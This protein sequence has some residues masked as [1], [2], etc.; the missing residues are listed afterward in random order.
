MVFVTDISGLENPSMIQDYQ[1]TLLDA[2]MVYTTTHYPHYPL[3][4]GELLLRLSEVQRLTSISRQQIRHLQ[5]TG[6]VPR[7]N[8][9]VELLRHQGYA[10]SGAQLTDAQ[11]L[12]VI[13][14]NYEHEDITPQHSFDPIGQISE[15]HISQQ[16]D[17]EIVEVSRKTSAEGSRH[18]TNKRKTTSVTRIETTNGYSSQDRTPAAA[19]IGT[20]PSTSVRSSDFDRSYSYGSNGSEQLPEDLTSPRSRDKPSTDVSPRP[21]TSPPLSDRFKNAP[22]SRQQSH[23]HQHVQRPQAI[24]EPEIRRPSTSSES[25]FRDNYPPSLHNNHRLSQAAD[26]YSNMRSPVKSEQSISSFSDRERI[27]QL[28]QPPSLRPSNDF[29]D[30]MHLSAMPVAFNPMAFSRL[31]TEAIAKRFNEQLMAQRFGAGN[32]EFL[33]Q[34]Y[35]SAFGI[36]NFDAMP[37]DY[38]LDGGGGSGEGGRNGGKT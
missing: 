20:P 29:L 27:R 24:V 38:S 9:L 30:M 35:A 19:S 34:R 15:E 17:E 16:E 8:L 7:Y 3:K 4:F 37:Q 32:P 1:N 21:N 12:H 26:N 31:N 14:T 36:S 33:A 18:V 28:P 10:K 13:N 22:L 23:D 5:S 2:L 11:A 6:E 25:N